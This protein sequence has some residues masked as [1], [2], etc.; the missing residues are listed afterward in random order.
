MPSRVDLSAVRS[1]SPPVPRP[2]R[3]SMAS[4]PLIDIPP[5]GSVPSNP[6]P[7]SPV[8]SRHD[9]DDDDGVTQVVTTLKMRALQGAHGKTN[10]S[11]PPPP[12]D[13]K[14]LAV[15]RAT[16]RNARLRRGDR[17]R[18][19]GEAARATGLGGS[20]SHHLRGTVG[21]DA[22][23]PSHEQRAACSAIPSA[24][25]ACGRSARRALIRRQRGRPACSSSRS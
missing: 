7:S 4:I 20:C 22:G 21:D 23:K 2:S 25:A 5:L 11:P 16:A 24:K 14:A 1:T 12:T 15:V 3:P 17:G 13:D 19:R 8:A 10:A 6:R 18:K 9:D